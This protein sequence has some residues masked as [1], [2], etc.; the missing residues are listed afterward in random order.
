MS[1]FSGSSTTLQTLCEVSLEACDALKPMICSFYAAMNDE[2]SKQK[3]DASIFTIAD[4]LVQHMLVEHLFAGR[5]KAVVG[6]EECAV[7]ISTRPFTVDDLVV[8]DE[9]C[10]IV[11]A[12]A[13]RMRALA[14]RLPPT[15]ACADLSVFVDPIDGTREFSTGLGEQS[16]VCIGFADAA[17]R[18]VAGLVY[19][20]VPSPATWAAGAR[21]EGFAAQRLERA[22]PA[23]A[24]GLLTSNG[25]ISSFLSGLL[26]EG[27]QRVPSGGAGNKMLLLLE[28]KGAAYIQ[29]RGVSRWDTCGA[30]AVLEA[31]GGALCKLSSFLQGG[32]AGYTYLASDLN[33]D[34]EPGAAT[35][36]PFNAADKGAVVKGA[37][38]VP[39]L[40]AVQ[41]KPYANLCGLVA[42]A[43]GSDP[44][45]WR[46][47]CLRTAADS[48]P[49]YD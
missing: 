8:P 27:L 13:E 23:S 29:D 40:E 20:P 2:T 45:A 16:S 39:A 17:G 42:L 25:G 36:T 32:A 10:T 47:R 49:A 22:E 5:F 38:P 7:N 24:Q 6:E 41:V 11:E 14:L 34:F 30:Q 15:G 44:Q 12:A 46:E 28:G 19:R 1:S 18:P 43:A 26:A 35:L 9:F 37:P 48:A 33:L 21:A 3:A 4:G 31:H